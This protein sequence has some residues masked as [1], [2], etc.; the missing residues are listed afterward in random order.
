ML[1][2]FGKAEPNGLVA[3]NGIIFYPVSAGV[4]VEIDARINRLINVGDIEFGRWMLWRSVAACCC[5]IGCWR[6]GTGIV[7]FGIAGLFWW[8]LSLAFAA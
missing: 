3:G 8:T 2:Y 6:G 4:L 5:W 1:V 7:R